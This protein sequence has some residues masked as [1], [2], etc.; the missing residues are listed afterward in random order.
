VSSGCVWRSEDNGI[1]WQPVLTLPGNER[2]YGLF[3]FGDH[4]L[5]AVGVSGVTWVSPD[6]I[7]W[8]RLAVDLLPTGV[9]CVRPVVMAGK[10]IYLGGWPAYG[11]QLA[12]LYDGRSVTA[13]GE[14][15]S[16][17]DHFS[18]GQN[19]VLLT[20]EGRIIHT[21]DLR[22]WITI[23]GTF[24]DKARSICLLDGHIFV[25]TSDS[26]LWRCAVEL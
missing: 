22:E 15:W 19:L 3:A 7:A 11:P 8:T 23:L 20:S 26:H 18:D 21:R 5:H 24:P 1:N 12:Y 6:G 17:L 25:G 13:I 9:V 14:P 4:L 2:I 16:V 10:A